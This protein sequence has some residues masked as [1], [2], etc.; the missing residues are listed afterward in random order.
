[1][2]SGVS[3]TATMIEAALKVTM[4][5]Y[6]DIKRVTLTDNSTFECSKDHTVCMSEHNILLYGQTMYQR[7]YGAKPLTRQLMQSIYECHQRLKKRINTGQEI[8]DIGFD[9]SGFVGHTWHHLFKRI[10]CQGC[11]YFTPERMKQL[12]QRFDVPAVMFTTWYISKRRIFT[13]SEIQIRNRRRKDGDSLNTWTILL[14]PNTK[15]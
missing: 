2:S 11:E 1:M 13:F 15:I 6:P 7:R 8:G 14:G 5:L 4:H 10:N 12:T 9:Y 3:G